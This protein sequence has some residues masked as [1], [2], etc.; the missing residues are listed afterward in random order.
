MSWRSD[1]EARLADPSWTELRKRLIRERGRKCECCEKPGNPLQAH[2]LHYQ[3]LWF[4]AD[5]DLQLLCP[6]CHIEADLDRAQRGRERAARALYD[7]RLDGWAQKKYGD[8]WG[9]EYDL[10]EI[11]NEFDLWLEEKGYS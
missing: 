8:C 10:N 6:P 7:A 9:C 4:E 1:Y 3:T 11:E 5:R 2:H